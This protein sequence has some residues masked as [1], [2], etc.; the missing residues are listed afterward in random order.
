MA[1][2]ASHPDP[3]PLMGLLGTWRGRGSGEYP[4]I[5]DFEYVE[6]VTFGHVG[7]PFLTYRQATRHAVDDRPLHAEVGYWR[8]VGTDRV[9]VVL[10]HPTGI[11][12][13]LEGSVLTG[14]TTVFDLRTRSVSLTST[15]K[16]V[17]EL[18]RH[19]ELTGDTLRYRLAMA[20][21]GHPLTHH[22]E[23]ELHRVS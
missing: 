16:E 12:E 9:E 10:A 15:A 22:L 21:V 2:P 5:E 3:D 11:A 13:I 20:A 23:A 4:T 1:P 7:K 6:E 19:L 17:T 18:H 8:P 14:A